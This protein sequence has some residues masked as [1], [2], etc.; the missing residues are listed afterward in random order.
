MN[1]VNILTIETPN[2]RITELGL[3]FEG[4][5]SFDQWA[6]LGIQAGRLVRASLFLIGDWLVYGETRWNGGERFEAL[7]TEKRDRY[8]V[9]MQATGLELQTLQKAAHVARNIPHD[10]RRSDLTF[11]HHKEVARIKDTDERAEWLEKAQSQGLSTRRLR[12]SIILGH[13]AQDH[14][15]QT[16]ASDKGI[17]NHLPWLNRLGAWWGEFEGCGWFEQATPEQVETFLRDFAQVRQVIARIETELAAK[18]SR[19]E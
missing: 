5:I 19:I 13:I 4:D 3:I 8:V 14:E 16:P 12:K 18:E 15:M 17:S 7:S 2:V 11:E 9:A 10:Q 1:P 6:E